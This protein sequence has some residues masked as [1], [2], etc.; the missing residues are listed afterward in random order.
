MKGKKTEIYR[1]WTE[2]EDKR[3]HEAYQRGKIKELAKE[4]D[5][6]EVAIYM[7]A[8]FFG[9]KNWRKKTWSAR[10]EST[11]K[12][13]WGLKSPVEIAELLNR[14]LHAVNL[15]ASKL[16]LRSFWTNKEKQSLRD[17]WYEE[18]LDQLATRFK[19]TQEAIKQQAKLLELKGGF[20]R[21]T[22]AYRAKLCKIKQ[23][24]WKDPLYR[25]KALARLKVLNK[26]SE[27]QKARMKA[28]NK[29][30]NSLERK[31]IEIC[32]KENLPYK[33]V[34]DGNFI[35]AGLN[36]DFVNVNGQKKIIEIFGDYW[37]SDE[38]LKKL[39]NWRGTEFGRK[40][41][42]SQFGFQTLVIWGKE[43]ADLNQVADKI[44]R[45]DEL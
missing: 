8:Q 33:F 12:D 31:I 44:K 21:R 37:H 22:P 20:R 26:D 28:M 9:L 13:W 38:K 3:I 39:K 1:Y 40:A 24:L 35:L 19:R 42:F 10:E 18:T 41:V 36:P 25:S 5:R 17:F 30:P 2:A 23:A 7:R 32:H 15:H 11:L 29:T 27:F 14:S 34:G 6:T 43:F 45:F 4:L 16:K